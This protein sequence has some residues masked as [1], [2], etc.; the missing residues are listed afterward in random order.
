MRQA[1]MQAPPVQAVR[2]APAPGSMV[3]VTVP[4]GVCGGQSLQVN[5]PVGPLCVQVPP[6]LREGDTFTV[7]LPAQ[8]APAA[9]PGACGASS[10][11]VPIGR[12]V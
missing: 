9:M 8:T 10:G 12:P 11:A 2:L 6:M 7:E 1:V 4:Q 3:N 5:T